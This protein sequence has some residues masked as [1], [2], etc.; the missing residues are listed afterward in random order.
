M[1]LLHY[2]S[3]VYKPIVSASFVVAQEHAKDVA[4]LKVAPN[5]VTS[6]TANEGESKK[7]ALQDE[8][9][10]CRMKAKRI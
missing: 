4:G 9:S 8:L 1:H 3:C 7:I 6:G 2:M 5:G 10:D